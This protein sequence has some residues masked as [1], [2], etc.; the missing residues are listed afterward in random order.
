MTPT[1][2]S[3]FGGVVLLQLF[4][5]SAVGGSVFSLLETPG[6]EEDL[7]FFVFCWFEYSTFFQ[8]S[9]TVVAQFVGAY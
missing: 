6:G 9:G 7:M 2:A 8:D 1:V 4:A 5:W 3:L